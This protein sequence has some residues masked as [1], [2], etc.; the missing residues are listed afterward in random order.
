MIGVPSATGVA[1]PASA[2]FP[3]FAGPLAG[4][5]AAGAPSGLAALPPTAG[6]AVV[7]PT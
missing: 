6:A 4:G 2:P 1:V 7:P 5:A 3:F